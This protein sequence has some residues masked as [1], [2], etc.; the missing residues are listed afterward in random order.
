MRLKNTAPE[1][2]SVAHTI[3]WWNEILWSWMG[4]IADAA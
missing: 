3:V 1:R 4:G 2:E